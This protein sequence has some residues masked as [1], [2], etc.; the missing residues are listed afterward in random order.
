MVIC[1]Y[2]DGESPAKDYPQAAR[3]V[4]L[5][6]RILR[7]DYKALD[8]ND[9]FD[10]YDAL[11]SWPGRDTEMDQLYQVL[12]AEHKRRTCAGNPSQAALT[13]IDGANGDIG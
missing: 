4:K 13:Q 8:S 7:G 2:L 1:W 6:P 10:L 9:L 5:L 3:L 11:G 12:K